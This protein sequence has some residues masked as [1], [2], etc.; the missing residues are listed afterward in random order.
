MRKTRD[1]LPYVLSSA[2][3]THR[4]S[5]RHVNDPSEAPTQHYPYAHHGGTLPG[6]GDGYNT[7]N[8]QVTG[9]SQGK[10]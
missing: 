6:E 3:S 5:P 4:C 7:L 8:M 10:M 1:I 9:A 2:A